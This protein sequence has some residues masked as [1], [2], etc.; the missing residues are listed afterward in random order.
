[1]EKIPV[2]NKLIEDLP[3]AARR[4]LADFLAYLHFKHR[5]DDARPVVALR[6]LWADVAFDVTDDD[7]RALRQR[8]S[9]RLVHGL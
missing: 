6:G 5:L 8:V 3:P 2:L 1:M 4:E 7:V 9:R